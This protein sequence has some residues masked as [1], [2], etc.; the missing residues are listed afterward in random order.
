MRILAFCVLIW[1]GVATNAVGSTASSQRITDYVNRCRRHTSPAT[2]SL[3]NAVGSQ[4]EKLVQF[5][6]A[7]INPRQLGTTSNVAAGIYVFPSKQAKLDCIAEAERIHKITISRLAKLQQNKE[8]IFLPMDGKRPT[9]G[10][11]GRLPSSNVRIAQV[12][13]PTDMLIQVIWSHSAPVSIPITRGGRNYRRLPGHTQ[14]VEFWVNG[15]QTGN[16]AND[17]SHTL[18]QVFS[19]TGN[20]TYETVDGST[21]TVFVIEPVDLTPWLTSV[22][23]LRTWTSDDGKFSTRAR[24]ISTTATEV[25]LKKESGS[26]IGVPLNKL[27]TAD[28]Q[29]VAAQR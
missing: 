14:R 19:I 29:Y 8:L 28:Q 1:C 15:I 26:T 4:A 20:K 7:S 27:S 16:L 6:R 12:T 13:G 17:M 18:G 24:F 25:T 10:Q 5:R 2:A 11:I 23:A 3:E 22:V 21:Q 9:V